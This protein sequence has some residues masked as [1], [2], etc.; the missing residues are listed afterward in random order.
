[1]QKKRAHYRTKSF[2]YLKELGR[3]HDSFS[4]DDDVASDTPETEGLIHGFEDEDIEQEMQ[5]S[6][7]E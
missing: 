2:F 6:E 5:E 3:E 7:E 4:S 1:M